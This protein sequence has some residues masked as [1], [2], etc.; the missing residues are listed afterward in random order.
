MTRDDPRQGVKIAVSLPV[1]AVY[2]RRIEVPMRILVFSVFCMI[3]VT[4]VFLVWAG[5]INASWIALLP[6]LV[7]GGI[8]FFHM[9]KTQ[10]KRARRDRIAIMENGDV[11]I[12]F[13]FT[14]AYFPAGE[15]GTVKIARSRNGRCWE[16]GEGSNLL[17]INRVR[18]PL[19][20]FPTLEQA[21]TQAAAARR[22]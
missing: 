8:A 2:R 1:D 7:I 22:G 19:K 3:G 6:A 18:V 10:E 5:I 11:Q 15:D 20:A 17:T 14:I 9:V 4:A 13:N 16:I 12:L 21:Y